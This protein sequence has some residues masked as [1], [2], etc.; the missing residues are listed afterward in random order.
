MANLDRTDYLQDAAG[1]PFIP[2]QLWSC[3]SA[4]LG[5]GKGGA[6]K[7]KQMPL[8]ASHGFE[9]SVTGRTALFRPIHFQSTFFQ[10]SGPH[11]TNCYLTGL[12]AS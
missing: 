7:A 6:F 4:P 3:P 5:Q 11:C 8:Q 12:G 1:S 2:I 9:H 10:F